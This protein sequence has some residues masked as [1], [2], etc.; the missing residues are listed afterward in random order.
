[1]TKVYIRFT[2]KTTDHCIGLEDAT[3]DLVE[4]EVY[5]GGFFIDYRRYE[6]KCEA[7]I[8]TRKNTITVYVFDG[9]ELETYEYAIKSWTIGSE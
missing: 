1:M 9:R 7:L 6:C 5:I 3:F 2:T 4:S 8:D